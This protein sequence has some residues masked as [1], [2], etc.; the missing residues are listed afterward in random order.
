M[1]DELRQYPCLE[2]S[3]LAMQFV[4]GG[5]EEKQEKQLRLK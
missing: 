1:V 3:T 4:G 5:D 2:Q